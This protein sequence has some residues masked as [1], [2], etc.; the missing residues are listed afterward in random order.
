MLKKNPPLRKNRLQRDMRIAAIT[1]SLGATLVTRNRR[2][3][4][5]VP[6]LLIVDWSQ[7]V[8]GKQPDGDR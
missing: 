4:E 8:D 3:F 7:L 6:E 1:L 5:L 2:D